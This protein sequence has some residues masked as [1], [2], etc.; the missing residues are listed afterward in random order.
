MYTEALAFRVLIYIRLIYWRSKLPQMLELYT[1]KYS[2][3]L[4]NKI[5]VYLSTFTAGMK[6]FRTT[7]DKDR[8]LIIIMVQGRCKNT[9]G[10]WTNNF[11]HDLL[12]DENNLRVMYN[13]DRSHTAL[14]HEW[15]ASANDYT[16]HR[17]WKKRWL[18]R[19]LK[20]KFTYYP[21][22][23]TYTNSDTLVAY[24][25]IL[26]IL[27]EQMAKEPPPCISLGLYCD[28][29]WPAQAC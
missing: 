20:F 8:Q 15:P 9:P 25:T 28:A 7:N 22:C 18:N 26:T 2:K 23:T 24:K 13:I 6:R 10:G 17:Y 27:H 16:S 29:D 19:K 4:V 12:Y 5:V 11:L 14:E 21:K 3:F 1:K